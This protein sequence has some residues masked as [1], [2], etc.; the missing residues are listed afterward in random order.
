VRAA[1]RFCDVPMDV[2]I[3]TSLVDPPIVKKSGE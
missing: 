3:V 2:F 1:S